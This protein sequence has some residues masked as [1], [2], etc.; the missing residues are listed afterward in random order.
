MGSRTALSSFQGCIVLEKKLSWPAQRANDWHIMDEAMKQL[1]FKKV[2]I[3][4][5]N[6]CRRFLQYVT[7]V[8]LSNDAGTHILP[9]FLTGN[10][11]I[12]S[13]EFSG[14]LFYQP[15]PGGEAWRSWRKFWRRYTTGPDHR[16]LI[17]LRSWILPA[18]QCCR[19]PHWVYDPNS[20][21]LYQ[22]G[23]SGYYPPLSWKVELPLADS[24]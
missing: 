3:D 16:L 14:E 10:V 5:I 12:H 8:D 17:P 13:C 23:Q 20:K 15:N 24:P 4:G 2:H 18:G 7:A 9:Q 22:R 21:S 11:E 6:A 19:R 1:D